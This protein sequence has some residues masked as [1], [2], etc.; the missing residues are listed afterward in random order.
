L[1]KLG[2]DGIFANA[3]VRVQHVYVHD[4]R[5]CLGGV[6][7]SGLENAYPFILSLPQVE[8]VRL[9][10]ENLTAFPSITYCEGMAMVDV[11]PLGSEV[12]VEAQDE[13]TG[14]KQTWRAAYV[15]GCDGARSNVREKMQIPSVVKPYGIS[16]LM[17]DFEDE[18]GLTNEAHLFF[19]PNGSVE[20]FPLPNQRRRWIVLTSRYFSRP[21]MAFLMGRVRALTAHDLRPSHV[22]WESTFAVQR[23]ASQRY[24]NGR[25]ILCGDAAHVMSPIGGQGMNTGFA[26]A[27]FLRDVLVGVLRE[28]LDAEPLLHHYDRCRKRAFCIAARRA[29]L[30]MW[31]GT[32]TGCLPSWLR[33]AFIGQVLLRSP[34]KAY[35]PKH[36]AM[37]T[38]HQRGLF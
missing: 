1:K 12:L 18:S 15:V 4:E 5:A 17:G 8:T 27:A 32:R 25:V 21:D 37:L 33:S 35:L 3:G 13:A 6:D 19:T 11:K 2:L 28:G 23:L 38:I 36:F 20:S 7:F 31:L 16:F 26:D 22:V 9:L 34:V 14:F 29:A 30:G 24:Y 10:K